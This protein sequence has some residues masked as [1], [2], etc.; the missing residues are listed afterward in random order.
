M[1]ATPGALENA[2]K[3]GIEDPQKSADC[4]KCHVT[5]YGEPKQNFEATFKPEDGIQ[6]ETCHGAGTDYFKMT[7]MKG[8]RAGTIERDKVGL[9]KPNKETCARCHNENST[10][11]KPVDWSADSTRIAHPIPRA[12]G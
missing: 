9:L 2:R 3:K 5:G 1:L 6:C 10:S 12:E 8:V 4:L 11:G 7:T